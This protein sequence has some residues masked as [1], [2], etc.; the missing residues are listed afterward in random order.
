[1]NGEILNEAMIFEVDNDQIHMENVKR[2]ILINNIKFVSVCDNIYQVT[3]E[4]GIRIRIRDRRMNTE[5]ARDQ[6]PNQG[7]RDKYGKIQ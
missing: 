5:R 6:D 2:H 1:M 7:M 3:K 4:C